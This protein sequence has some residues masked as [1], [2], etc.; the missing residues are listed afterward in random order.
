M[1]KIILIVMFFIN[2]VATASNII[3][4]DLEIY[5]MK[6]SELSSILSSYTKQTIIVDNEAR[7]I[8]I[9]GYFNAGT[10][11]DV[12]IDSIA[13]ANNLNVDY[14]ENTIILSSH[15]KAT[16]NRV[17]IIGK[18]YDYSNGYPVKNAKI[19]IKDL[20]RKG[21]YTDSSGNF[22]IDS[23]PKD[24]YIIKVS[25]DSFED[26]GEIIQA[27]KKN[28]AI[29]IFLTRL[30]V[31][32]EKPIS[33]FK[34]INIGDKILY[35][36]LF[37]L[38]EANGTE[39]VKSLKDLYNDEIK[40]TLNE[41]TN[42][43]LVIASKEILLNI[44]DM[45]NS[46]DKKVKQVRIESEI[47]DVSNNLF[48]E[49]GFEWAYGNKEQSNNNFSLNLLN[50][51]GG[52]FNITRQ[53]T[54]P[55]SLLSFSF[56]FL[57]TNN[58]LH[59]SSVP[60]LTIESGKSGEFKVSEEIVVGEKTKKEGKK[61]ISEPMFKEAG[62]IM[63]VKPIV[64][65]NQEIILEIE[66]EVSDFKF[67][68]SLKRSDINSG[69]VNAQGGSKIGRTIKTRVRLKNEE[70]ILIGGL[71]RTLKNNSLNKVP[72]IGDIPVIGNLFKKETNKRE[73]S[74]MY[75]KIKAFIVD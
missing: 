1:N 37:N 15:K 62:I 49:L 68:E 53:F 10:S 65:D 24:S 20:N 23:I 71:K 61:I 59:I 42:Q 8:N 41:S 75:I 18:V 74:D 17:N 33:D 36:N 44:Q 4:E 54:N 26:K 67:K 21:I 63:K 22:I 16:D 13:S 7:N 12:I 27:D 51:S 38:N 66:L 5:D 57:E 60:T 2:L 64:T 69:T 48:D 47:V 56:K 73:S 11:V 55:S 9:D 32:N 46:F 45:L 58:D 40:I 34:I 39:I 52:V 50:P 19:E 6:L 28:N 14:N 25:A 70:T 72:V 30:D 3:N 29:N 35:S 43:I 31:E